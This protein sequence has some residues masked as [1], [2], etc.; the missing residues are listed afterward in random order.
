MVITMAPR[1]KSR[2]RGGGAKSSSKSR[3]KSGTSMK[4]S[5]SSSSRGRSKSSSKGGKSSGKSSSTKMKSAGTSGT[6]E[7]DTISLTTAPFTTLYYFGWSFYESLVYY[8]VEFVQS[9]AF[10]FAL[11]PLLTVYLATKFVLFPELYTPPGKCGSRAA[12]MGASATVGGTKSNTTKSFTTTAGQPDDSAF[13]G[14]ILWQVELYTLEILWWVILGILSSVGFGT[15]LHS[16]LMFLFPHIMKVVFASETC[17][18]S[19]MQTMY[20]HPC[21]FECGK[22]FKAGQESTATLFELWLRVVVPVM[23]WGFGTAVGELP[24][25]F[26]SRQASMTKG[27][28]DEE[29][30]RELEES[31]GATDAFS[32]MKMMTIDFTE[33]YGFLVGVFLLASWPNAAFDMCG[34][35]CGYLQMPFWT[36][37]L[38][39]ALG[40]G[41]VKVNLQA[42]FFIALFGGTFFKI[43]LVPVSRLLQSL[44]GTLKGLLPDSVVKTDVAALLTK[45]R[46]K[47]ISKFEKQARVTF[48]EA[49]GGAALL[50]KPMLL[51]L[52][53]GFEK[54][55]GVVERILASFDANKDGKLSQAELGATIS[56]TDGKFALGSLDPEGDSDSWMKML[57]DLFLA[58]VIGFFFFSIIQQMA[59]TKYAE[60]TSKKKK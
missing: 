23:A 56:G 6:T 19:D 32:K 3:S 54:P 28:R 29:F 10:L 42:L 51:K 43:V 48:A 35:C 22:P 4:K 39:T 26:I 25:Y 49:T 9:Q 45:Q 53:K 30:E 21:K 38:A 20:L 34:M 12:A 50:T 2:G 40:K 36:F 47:I 33:K 11:L 13:D 27:K 60:V 58:G 14:G 7:E 18:L 57:W 24:P 59:A 1:E 8:T 44:L 46:Q 55:E 31:R 37:F 17:D 5:K 41:V 15:G 52:Y 16:G